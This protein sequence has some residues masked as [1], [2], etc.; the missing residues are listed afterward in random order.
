MPTM[1]DVATLAGVSIATVSF[2]V[3]NT[4]NV[5]PATR[6]RVTA[7]MAELGYR[8][9]VVARALASRR[10]RIM[11][12]LF[13]SVEH[14]L[15]GTATTFFMGA[16][17]CAAELGYHLVL[18]P[19][20]DDADDIDD[21]ISG[22][23]MDGVIVMEIKMEDPRIDQLVERQMPFVAIGRTRDP[24][25]L[26]YVDIDFETTVERSLDYLQELGH[27]N[28]AL[29]IEDME[30][31][32]MAGYAPHIRTEA[33][34]LSSAARRGMRASVVRCGPSTAGGRQAAHD[35]VAGDP[36]LTAVLIM[37]D[38]ST[39]GLMRGL[40]EQGLRV[41][42]DV[43]VLSLASST[44][45]GALHDPPLST[46]DSPSRE[47]GRMAAEALIRKLDGREVERLH[48]LLPCVLHVAGSTAPAR[49]RARG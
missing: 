34:F 40:A 31:S 36:D 14:R 26:S 8:N 39:F 17:E 6:D 19:N 4:K 22:G 1:Q 9:N 45:A 42:D 16:A 23:L 3:N 15:G 24:D 44:A 27:S 5:A 20:G 29:V 43:S 25:G 12:L 18:W 32:P 49:A 37:K 21:L 35:A 7:A 10:T 30:G 33:T 41:P 46:L 48:L 13:P 11:A 47:L 28:A 2:V 38:D